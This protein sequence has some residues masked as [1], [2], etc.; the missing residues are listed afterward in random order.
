MSNLSRVLHQAQIVP[1]DL[2]TRG[3][4]KRVRQL[5]DVLDSTIFT[6]H[7]SHTFVLHSLF[8]KL[9]PQ[10]IYQPKH[11]YQFTTGVGHVERARGEVSDAFSRPA[12][13][14]LQPSSGIGLTGIVFAPSNSN[15]TNSFCLLA[16]VPLSTTSPLPLTV[17][18]CRHSFVARP[19]RFCST[20]L[21]VGVES[22]TSWP[23]T[24]SSSLGNTSTSS[25]ARCGDTK[26]APSAPFPARYTVQRCPPE[27]TYQL[28]GPMHPV[29]GRCPSA[30]C[31]G[32]NGG[33][34]VLQSLD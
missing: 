29:S 34:A 13:T 20:Y 18:F 9:N 28:R 32:S 19:Y 15:F 11:I 31:R 16:T 22:P 6:D 5:I 24:V 25:E 21:T 30:R 3:V 33:Q 17:P 26:G 27:L 4:T 7:K 2:S 14:H 10:K 12:I 1:E 8:D 23:L